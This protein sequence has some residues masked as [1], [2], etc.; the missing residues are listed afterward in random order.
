MQEQNKHIEAIL[1]SLEG[2]EQAEANPFLFE[3]IQQ[4]MST[5]NARPV[6]YGEKKVVWV[7]A[8]LTLMVIVNGLFLVKNKK[9]TNSQVALSYQ[10]GIETISGEY[11]ESN[12]YSY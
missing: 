5:R 12:T 7:T 2:I 8:V 3:K 9:S 4:R 1:N 10:S 11:F 6:L